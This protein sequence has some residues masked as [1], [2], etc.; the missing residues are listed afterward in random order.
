MLRNHLLWIL[1][2]LLVNENGLLK[3]N[4]HAGEGSSGIFG[5]KLALWSNEQNTRVTRIFS[6]VIMMAIGLL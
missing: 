3:R 5:C 2:A 1:M 4:G 6:P